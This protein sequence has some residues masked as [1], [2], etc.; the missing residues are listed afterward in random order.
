MEPQPTNAQNKAKDALVASIVGGL[1]ALALSPLTTPLSFMLNEHLARP[2]LR[3]EYVEIVREDAPVPLP[4]KEIGEV[5]RSPA[6]RTLL[7]SG[8]GFDTQLMSF[9][10][11]ESATLPEAKSLNAAVARLIFTF[12]T[13]HQE[14]VGLQRTLD[15]QPNEKQ[16][17]DIVQRYSL[18]TALMSAA[19]PDPRLLK[20]MV[21]PRIATDI[22]SLKEGI[23]ASQRLKTALDRLGPSTRGKIWL[24]V[25]IVNRGSTDGL[26][27]NAGEFRSSGIDLVHI[28]R[29]NGPAFLRPSVSASHAGVPVNVLNAPP[30]EDRASG[31]GKVEKHSLAEFWFEVDDTNPIATRDKLWNTFQANSL[32]GGLLNLFDHENKTLAFS[33]PAINKTTKVAK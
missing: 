25:S 7:Q 27:R 28:K 24:K 22:D 31:V 5:V 13:R 16:L 1:V 19:V 3:V 21:I 10:D 26:V 30:V 12:R 33:V 11:R 9:R 23:Q 20:N 17:R 2:I 18:Q 29:S 4:Y 8:F 14:L 32:S 6:Y 15:G